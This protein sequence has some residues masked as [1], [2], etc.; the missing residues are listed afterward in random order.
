MSFGKITFLI[1]NLLFVG[2]VNTFCNMNRVLGKTYPMCKR[3]LKGDHLEPDPVN[4]VLHHLEMRWV[5]NMYP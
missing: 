5:R 4:S 3:D 1:I 2:V